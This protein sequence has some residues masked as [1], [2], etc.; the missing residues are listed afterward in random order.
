[1]LTSENSLE[2]GVT[3]MDFISSA[4]PSVIFWT[5]T[6]IGFCFDHCQISGIYNM[7]EEVANVI[8]ST[9]MCY[10]FDVSKHSKNI[11]RTCVSLA[12]LSFYVI[13][14]ILFG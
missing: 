8:F 12:D 3:E 13:L 9:S 10:S 1:M 4:L 14:I 6:K 11:S 5:K 7:T 2:T